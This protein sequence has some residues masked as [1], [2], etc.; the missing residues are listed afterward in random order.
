M[1]AMGVINV[2]VTEGYLTSTSRGPT[3]PFITGFWAHLVG[4]LQG[5]YIFLDT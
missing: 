1:D 3:I 2:W 4:N 5:N